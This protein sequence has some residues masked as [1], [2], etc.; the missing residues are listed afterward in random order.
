MDMEMEATVRTEALAEFFKALSDPNRLRIVGLLSDKPYTVEQL[1]AL[2]GLSNSTVSHHLSM[3]AQINLVSARGESYYRE[4][5]LNVAALEDMAKR[6][7]IRET[8]TAFAEDVDL[9]AYDQKVLKT[10]LLPDGTLRQIP[11]QRKKLEV[12]LR[13]ILKDFEGGRTYTEAEVNAIIA[14]YSEDIS[15]LR[16]DF[17]EFKLLDRDKRGASYRLVE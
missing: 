3:L 5:S 15:G 7:L 4:Y 6:L 13:Y 9:D 17:I 12:I 16:R 11:S 14:R 2:L 8:F 1:A 10:Y